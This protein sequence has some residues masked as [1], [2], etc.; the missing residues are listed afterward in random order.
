MKSEISPQADPGYTRL[1]ATDAS[2]YEQIPTGVSFPRCVEDCIALVS[3]AREDGVSLIGRGGG[4]SIAGQ[5]VGEG[6]IVDFSRFMAGILSLPEEGSIWVQ[7][8]VVLDD[9]NDYLRPFGLQ[10]PID[11]STSSRCTIGGMVGNN[12][13]GSHSIIYGTTRENVLEVDAVLADGGEVRFGPIDA[14]ALSV[15]RLA[16]GLEGN[17]YRA[18]FEAIDGHRDAILAAFPDSSVIRRNTGYALDDLAVGQPWMEYGRPFNLSSIICGS[19]GTLALLTAIRLKLSPLVRGKALACIHFASLEAALQANSFLL[20]QSGL[21]AC[22]LIDA[23]ILR[24]AANHSG[25]KVNRAWVVGDPSAVLVAEFFAETPV[26]AREKADQAAANLK[27]A[28]IGIAWPVLDGVDAPR[29]WALRKAGMGLL[30]G[31]RQRARPVAVIEDSAVPVH[32][33]PDFAHEI[34]LMMGRHGLDCVYYGHASVGLLHLRPTLDLDDEA[35]RAVFRSVAEETAA[36]VKHYRGSLSGEHGDGRVRA[37][38]LRQF[39]GEEVYALLCQV[40]Q[41]FDPSGLFNPGKII[42]GQP[43]DADFRKRPRTDAQ[44]TPAGLDWQADGG[45][46]LVLE[47]CNGSGNCRQAT[48]RGAM[49]PTFQAT[50]EELHSTRGR[51]NLLRQAFSQPGAAGLD[52]PVLTEAMDTCLS[53]KACKSECPSGVDMT[54]MKMEY[55]YRRG[56]SRLW[57]PLRWLMGMQPLLLSLFAMLPAFLR[58]MSGRLVRLPWVMKFSGLERELPMPA[59]MALSRRVSLRGVDKAGMAT[60]LGEDRRPLLLLVDPYVNHLE[61]EIGEAAILVLQR[62]GYEPELCF[63]DCSLRLLVSEGFLDEARNGLKRLRDD[64]ISRRTMPVVGLEPA[65]LLLLRD[66]AVTLLGDAWPADLMA[67]CFMLDEF[68]LREHATG[69]LGIADFQAMGRPVYFHPHCHERVAGGISTTQTLLISVFGYK[70]EA[71]SSGCCGMGGS[72]GY[73]HNDLSR[74]I[75]Q[76]NVCLPADNKDSTTILVSGTSCRHQFQ[77]QTG[78]K[79]QHLAEFLR[80]EL[81]S[82]CAEYASGCIKT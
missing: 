24:A 18:V 38:Y 66:E 70:A 8:G 25:Q 50:G 9:L 36:L 53:C 42:S 52:D 48:G 13:A 28:G 80:N 10:F 55:L 33:L 34:G 20:A 45:F 79:P 74:K 17:I 39:L 35:D 19:E 30:M 49:C 7:P 12:A 41:A 56:R 16:P 46:D 27:T 60:G 69:K 72:F 22:E 63:M 15:K 54:R 6:V 14:M 43:V 57:Q 4:T 61:P 67:R 59:P 31:L 32:A 64:L 5:C 78:A 40:K 62:L 73:Y 26:L 3:Q 37:P 76:N 81:A 47:R 29:V 2:V 21:S 77:E 23:H 58:I 71:I 1:Y 51:A 11:I 68:L 44:E 65:E 75:F 82:P